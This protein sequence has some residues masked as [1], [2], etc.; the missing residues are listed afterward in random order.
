MKIDLIASVREVFELDAI[1]KIETNDLCMTT[2]VIV[3]LA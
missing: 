2:V 1:L 3:S